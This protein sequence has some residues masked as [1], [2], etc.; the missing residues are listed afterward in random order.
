MPKDRRIEHIVVLMLENRSFDHMLG[1]AK[2]PGANDL[3]TGPYFNLDQHG[4]KVLAGPGAEYQGLLE[5]DPPHEFE[6]VDLQLFGD[7]PTRPATP[8]LSGFLR[9]YENAGGRNA[10]VMR[11]F[12]PQQL[13]ALTTLARNYLVCDRW[14]ASVPGPTNPNRAFAHFGTSFGQVESTI[15]WGGQGQGIYG[16]MVQ[17]GKR[18]KLFYYSKASGTIGM[19]FL[20]AE[21]F[22]DFED[23]RD[24]C[25]DPDALPEYSFLEPCYQDLDDD[26]IA[27][28][29]HP[30]HYVKAGDD[31][32]RDVYQAIRQNDDVW[33]STVLLVVWDEH[34]GFYDHVTPPALGYGDTYRS[35]HPDF[36]F[37]RL[38]VRVPAVIVSPYVHAGVSHQL[39]EHASI[40]ATA[41]EQ[42]IGDHSKKSLSLREQRANTFHDLLEQMPPR[43]DRPDFD[44]M[45]QDVEAAPPAARPDAKANTLQLQ[46][47]QHLHSL[48]AHANPKLAQKLDPQAVA[49]EAD[50]SAFTRRA[51]KVLHRN[52]PKSRGGA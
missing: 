45:A 50:V 15:L 16:R 13:P 19:S 39:F 1:L 33:R 31:L 44:A 42:F 10:A 32:I 27:S 29:M 23:F 48:L 38:G 40:P 34:G 24:A 8:D 5:A 18:A 6:H 51:L 14:F 28:D 3:S 12:E 49:T 46:Q 41:T 2:I 25:K 26:T 11:C 21:Y 35:H 4:N 36:A 9:S 52:P 7:G 43:M 37:D 47:V 20:P 17:A 30:D 22:G